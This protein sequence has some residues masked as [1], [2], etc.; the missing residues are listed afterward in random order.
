MLVGVIEG[1]YI[2]KVLRV[3]LSRRKTRVEPVNETFAMEFVGGRGWGAKILYD[4]IKGRIDAFS[5]EN[6]IVVASGPLSGLIVPCSGKT[7]F[8]AISPSTGLYGDSNIGGEFSCALKRS[9]FD[10]LIIE[11]SAEKPVILVIDDGN[12][13]FKDASHLWGMPSLDAERV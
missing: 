8:S 6:K 5:P 7:S 10:A 9:G 13:G 12:V 1:G 4:E 11:G 3:D 2:L